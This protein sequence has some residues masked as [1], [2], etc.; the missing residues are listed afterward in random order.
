[1]EIPAKH[2]LE[3]YA[4]QFDTVELNGVFYRTPTA[5]VVLSLNSSAALMTM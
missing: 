4:S 3:Y 5:D 1:M 2:H